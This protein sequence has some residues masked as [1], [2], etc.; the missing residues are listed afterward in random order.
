M[1]PMYDFICENCGHSANDIF[2]SLLDHNIEE[3]VT[4]TCGKCKHVMHTIITGGQPP[5]IKSGKKFLGDVFDEAAK[6]GAPQPGTKEYEKLAS[7]QIKKDR[8]KHDENL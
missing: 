7:E 5:I 4:Y 6:R 3:D 2:L 1:C 8:E